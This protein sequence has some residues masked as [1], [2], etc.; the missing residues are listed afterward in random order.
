[1]IMGNLL[2]LATV[3]AASGFAPQADDL[4]RGF[5]QPPQTARPWVYW[6]WLNGNI[7][8]T[9]ITA[10]LEAM[11]RVGIGGVLI[12]EV[13]QGAP[14]GKVPFMSLS[15]RDLF[16]HAVT[17]AQRLGL[18]VN[19]NNDAGWNGS[20]GPWIKP[21]HSMQEVVW[22][23]TDVSGPKQFVGTLGRPRATANYYRDIAVLAVPKKGDS[24]IPDFEAKAAYQRRT[25]PKPA[26]RA[27]QSHA[28]IAIDQ[29]LVLD[30]TGRMDDGGRISWNVPAGKWTILRVGHTS[31][32]ME[33]QPSPASGRGLE[34]DKLSP[35][36]IEA[37][38]TGMM[39]K[40]VEDVGPTTPRALVATHIDSWEN[41][42][43]NWTL[44]MREEFQKRRGYDMTRF[45]P[46]MTGRVL[47]SMEISE[48]FLWD[49][50][51]TI[52][53]LVIES[54]AGRMSQ[55]AHKRGLRFTVEAYGSPCD[56]LPYAGQADE[57][58]GEFWVGGGSIETCK[59]MASAGHIYA[60]PIIGAEAFTA[61]HH[62]RWTQHPATLKALG[63]RAFCEGI[64]RFVVHRYALQPWADLRPGMTMGPWGVHYERTQTWW[65]WTRPWHDYLARCQFLL[66]QGLFVADICYLQAESPP[67]GFHDHPRAG[68]DWDE[69]SAEVVINRMSVRDGRLVL[70][71]EM[72]YR[73]LVLPESSTM[74]PTLLRRIKV[75]VEAGA[76]VV[77][78]RPS[79]SP[80]L[81][82]YPGSDQEIRTLA[83]G[84]WGDCDGKAV[85]EHRVGKGR[86][87]CGM[88]PESV[89]ARAGVKP[90]FG[91]QTSLHHIHRRRGDVELYFVSNPLPSNQTSIC[92]FRVTGKQPELWW[93]DTGRIEPATIFADNGGTT[94]VSLPLGPIGSVFVLFREPAGETASITRLD[95]ERKL[96]RSTSQ[97][98][99]SSRIVVRRATYGV[100]GDRVRTRDV[101]AMVQQIVDAGEDRFEVA[102]LASGDDPAFGVVKTLVVEYSIE[103]CHRTVTA[104]DPETIVL[105]AAHSTEQVAD[106][107]R[108]ANG[109]LILDVWKPGRYDLQTTAGRRQIQVPSLPPAVQIDGPWTLV[110]AP[111]LGGPRRLTLD[112][113][114]S[115]SEQT[116]PGV[117][118]FS[119]TVRYAA[120][121]SVPTE[122]LARGRRLYLDLGKVEVMAQGWLN[123]KDLG[124]LWKPPFVVDVTEAARP[125]TNSLEVKVVNLWINRLIGDEQLSEDSLRNGNGTLKEWPRWLTDEKRSPTGR[126][127][128]TSWRLWK[129]ADVLVP[130][131]LLGPVRLLTTERIGVQ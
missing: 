75:L 102:R 11:K 67:Q 104:T 29:A 26:A 30:L 36:G 76:T 88:T 23:E 123:G 99:Q 28:P 63:D 118:Y 95:R 105:A 5:V 91:S 43:Q 55:L 62:E 72:S 31:T 115:W 53:E 48:R 38:F 81:S 129:K 70:P 41:G 51:R 37:N 4:A 59:G 40:L 120:D 25:Q 100:P 116:D 35:A 65:D 111:E 45:L 60:K 89:L 16:R 128:F 82:G 10:D 18:E 119:G 79:R 50:R 126:H 122:M 9:G 2:I 47:D 121:V 85:T 20:G 57:P 90:D 54:Y 127:T 106:A 73:L 69:C 49:L 86:I 78:P 17:E 66:R 98:E 92:S 6:F 77:G 80:S 110:L 7:T 101:R 56:Y 109:H 64:N 24:R 1:M 107:H 52:S 108:D 84:L 124:I 58:M 19:M 34:C 3:L 112:T 14:V 87:Y 46:V 83:E 12:M 21:E 27:Q 113:L 32:G 13:D 61:D 15:W 42:S 130:S 96:V 117:R 131:G 33:N 97:P 114:S 22:T 39:A 74:T 68:Y 125:G 71:D 94:N 44:R 93:P 103:E 8:K